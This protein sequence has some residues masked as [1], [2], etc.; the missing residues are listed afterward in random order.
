MRYLNKEEDKMMWEALRKS[1]T[2]VGSGRMSAGTT[3]LDACTNSTGQMETLTIEKLNEAMALIEKDPLA[4]YMRSKGFDP[5]KGCLFLIPGPQFEDIDWGPLGAPMYVRSA[6]I[7][8]EPLMI[9]P[10]KAGLDGFSI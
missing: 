9:D 8:A 4:E 7:I 3:L 5:D 1:S 2:I 10:K 6:R